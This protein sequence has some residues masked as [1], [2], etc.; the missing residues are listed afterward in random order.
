MVFT[1]TSGGP[2]SAAIRST[3][4]RAAAGSAGSAVSRRMP[5][6]SS[7]SPSSLRSTPITVNPA[8]ASF[9]A[10]ARPSSPPAPTTIATRS[11]MPPPPPWK[12][13]RKR[14]TRRFSFRSRTGLVAAGLFR[15]TTGKV[16]SRHRIP[17]ICRRS[18]VSYPDRVPGGAGA[19]T[20]MSAIG[21]SR[22][23]RGPARADRP[24]QPGRHARPRGREAGDDHLGG[25]RTTQALAAVDLV[26]FYMR[27][28]EK[29]LGRG[30]GPPRHGHRP[31]GHA[32]YREV[33]RRAGRR[34]YRDF[35][36]HDVRHHALVA[37]RPRPSGSV[38]P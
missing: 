29:P 36:H 17:V 7:F 13:R 6:G 14:M 19:T 23:G 34:G 37:S 11:L 30:Q 33:H 26:P 35:H 1:S 18:A 31:R 20:G 10:V 16:R 5:S 9:S 24:S 32:H 27:M 25:R 21:W 2:T 4:L 3:T 22:G 15:F 12:R 28:G 38:H 8:A